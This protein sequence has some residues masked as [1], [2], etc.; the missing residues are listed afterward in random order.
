MQQD[1]L[2]RVIDLLLHYSQAVIV[3]GVMVTLL[4]L[5]LLLL[6]GTGWAYFLRMKPG[7]R[8]W[9][10][11]ARHAFP[12]SDYR[13]VSSR[14]DFY[15]FILHFLIVGPVLGIFFK[16]LGTIVSSEIVRSLLVSAFGAPMPLI[17]NHAVTVAAQAAIMILAFD[18]GEF[19]GH[20][21]SHKVP[22][23]WSLHRAHHSA[24]SLI[25]FTIH[26]THPLSA[27]LTQGVIKHL[28]IGVIVGSFLYLTG[29]AADAGAIAILGYFYSIQ[30]LR[31]MLQHSRIRMS[32]GWLNYI[33]VAPVLHQVHHSAELRHRDVNMG[34]NFAIW[35]WM[36]GTLYVP[37]KRETW[38]VGLN[39]EEIG[40]TNPHVRVMD[41]YLEPIR[42]M[43]ST[44]VGKRTQH[45]AQVL[46]RNA[47]GTGGLLSVGESGKQ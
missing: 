6:I 30:L 23:L 19:V 36:F 43:I 9:M 33:F 47:P 10:A 24:E 4:A 32:F 17:S 40:S 16:L 28:C 27:L 2:D 41:F 12:L 14:S 34:A 15:N 26:R 18:F 44:C 38:R 37:D 3:P 35:D 11:A 46:E 13:A 31:V 20:Y 8:S 45:P 21:L 42:H 25:V 22:F 29:G 39:D 5:P 1:I 7:R